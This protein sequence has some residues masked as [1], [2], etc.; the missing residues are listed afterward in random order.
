MKVEQVLVVAM[1]A[2]LMA[3]AELATMPRMVQAPLWQW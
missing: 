2:V 3:V 1:G